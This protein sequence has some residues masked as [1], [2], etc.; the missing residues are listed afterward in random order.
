MNHTIDYYNNNA[1]QFIETT[2]NTSFSSIQERFLD[3]ISKGA[4]ILDFGCGSG[5][6]TKYFLDKGYK[7]TAV[8]G[9]HE[10]CVFAS[11]F[12]GTEVKQMMFQELNEHE[13]YDGIWA[14]ASILHLPK[15]ELI[16]VLSKMCDSLKKNGIMYTSF[17][18]GEFEGNRY[19]RY[20]IDMTE[21]RFGKLVNSIPNLVLIEQWVSNDVRPGREGE[22]WLNILLR[23]K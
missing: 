14:C 18:Y 11:Q 23:K 16:I 12:T 3:K 22:K 13:L 5:R 2:S 1:S 4:H 17:K 10:M 21:D 19:G 6:D 15:D 8:D 7:V 20:F 9:S